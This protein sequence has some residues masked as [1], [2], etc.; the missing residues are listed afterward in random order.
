MGA[1]QHDGACRGDQPGRLEGCLETVERD[2]LVGDLP[3][4]ARQRVEILKALYRDADILILDEPTG[5]LTPQE[6][7]DLFRILRALRA[8]GKTVILITHKLREIMAVSDRV[9]VM[10]Q[11]R[12][13]AHLDT[14][15]TGPEQLSELMVGRKVVLSVEVP[16]AE[17][18]AEE[19]FTLEL[20]GILTDVGLK[21]SVGRADIDGHRFGPGK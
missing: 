5:V 19:A 7:D 9:S 12:M 13:V 15:D 8:R 10:R 21:Y 3:V 1:R 2:A 20:P 14:R 6:A 4:G 11:G 17:P 18:R 16:P